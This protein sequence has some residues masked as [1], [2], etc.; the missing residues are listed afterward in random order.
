MTAQETATRRGSA[1]R[2]PAEIVRVAGPV[3]QARGGRSIRVREEVAV[4]EQRLV[5]EA[6]TLVGD[7]VTIQVYE[8]TSGL[9]PGDPV[10]GTG[11]MRFSNLMRFIYD[12]N[13]PF[14]IQD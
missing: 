4:G 9:R 6:V 1:E 7:E 5:G 12:N 8:D 2:E 10:F 14:C 11:L 13:I 3:V